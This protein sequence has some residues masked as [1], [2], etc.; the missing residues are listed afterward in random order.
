VQAAEH[1][2]VGVEH[3]DQVG[4]PQ[5]EPLDDDGGG[6]PHRRARGVLAP[7]QGGSLLDDRNPGTR[8]PA[9][10]VHEAQRVGLHVEAAPAAA[11]AR[12]SL[13]VDADVPDLHA[14]AGA[15][16]VQPAAQDERAA[17]TPV[18]GRH[19]QQVPGVAAGSVPVL[20][21]RGQVDVVGRRACGRGTAGPR[22][23]RPV[24]PSFRAAWSF[25]GLAGAALGGLLAPHLSPVRHLLLHAVPPY[26]V[27]RRDCLL[28]AKPMIADH[29]RPPGGSSYPR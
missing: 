14:E 17:H 6:G 28:Q 25:D 11:P 3:V 9:C 16:R 10:G 8:H 27:R 7:Q 19:D 21:Q 29:Y 4:Q 20:G 13:R 22:P 24:M 15:A 5:P 1:D 26:L 2:P 18:T 23:C 12:T